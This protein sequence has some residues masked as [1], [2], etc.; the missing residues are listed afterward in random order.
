[1]LKFW[2]ERLPFSSICWTIWTNHSPAHVNRK[3]WGTIDSLLIIHTTAPLHNQRLTV[4]SR[5]TGKW[6]AYYFHLEDS[7]QKS[8]SS[9][10]CYI[11]SPPI[12]NHFLIIISS[13]QCFLWLHSG[14][15]QLS[16]TKIFTNA[17]TGESKEWK[18]THCPLVL[19]AN[20]L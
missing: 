17:F 14:Y 5:D 3:A 12:P 1:M 10:I 16:K 6:S 9:Q 13:F 15:K 2:G 8:L 4:C 19:P 20:F 18:I 11:G 7:F